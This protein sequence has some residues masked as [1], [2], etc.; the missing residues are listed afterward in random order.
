MADCA[1]DRLGGSA[2][3][4]GYCGHSQAEGAT[5]RRERL[6]AATT[7]RAA[8]A[9]L[10]PGLNNANRCF[11]IWISQWFTGWRSS[12]LIVRAE[13]L[14]RWHRRSRRAYWSGGQG[15]GD[16]R[17]VA[18]A[19]SQR[20]QALIRRM[21]AEKSAGGSTTDPS[22]TGEIGIYSFGKHGRQIYGFAPWSRAV[23]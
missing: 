22:R 23:R 9:C 20:L 15:V 11:W 18:R 14:L 19:N 1:E 6:S 12:L 2:V 3:G 16:G 8:E 21:T 10:H 5:D 17:A 4:V 13:T 7:D